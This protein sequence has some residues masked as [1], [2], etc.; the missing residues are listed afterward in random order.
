MVPSAVTLLC[1]LG[2]AAAV[3]LGASSRTYD[4]RA[5]LAPRSPFLDSSRLSGQTSP[6]Q[7]RW[8]KG[9]THAH[10]LKADGDSSPEEL[11]RWYR[12]HNNYQFVVLTDHD[13]LTPVEPLNAAQA[14][15]GRFLVIAGEEVTDHAETKKAVHVNGLGLRTR[16]LPQGGALVS[17]V[18]ERDVDAIRKAGGVPVINH[19]NYQWAITAGDVLKTRHVNL[20]EIASGNPDVNDL[21]GGGLP[22]AE[23]LWDQVL[24]AGREMYGVAVDDAHS[25]KDPWNP[26]A[27]QPGTAWVVVRSS[28]LEADSILSAL[29]RGEFYAS[30]GVE[31]EGIVVTAEQ[32]TV[33]VKPSSWNKGRIQFV[34]RGGRLLKEA[35]ESPARYVFR[36][37]EGYVRARVM[38]SNGRMAWVQPV[39][40]SEPASTK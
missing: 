36:G 32:L 37:D 5:P 22:S 40:L 18:L 38:A 30:T 4:V 13:L 31:L 9:N 25:F 6:T 10:S 20:I 24:S 26:Q 23:E 7:L 1:G 19:P 29:D 2:M 35:I 27:K 21:G 11:A 15:E 12:E 28:A 16:V 34:G 17:D 14:V 39:F 8:Y 3:L 33:T